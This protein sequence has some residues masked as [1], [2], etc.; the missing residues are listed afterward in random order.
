[1]Y[2]RSVIQQQALTRP[3]LP[4]TP[5]AVLRA[6]AALHPPRQRPR[7]PRAAPVAQHLP[8]LGPQWQAQRQAA[9]A[10]GR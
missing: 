5:A 9:A 1:M 10:G 3:P 6:P 4:F 7:A 8:V 2:T